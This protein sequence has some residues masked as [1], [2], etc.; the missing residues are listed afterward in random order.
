MRFKL[1]ISTQLPL[2]LPLPD[3]VE[4]PL[5]DGPTTMGLDLL[6]FAIVA[7][8]NCK[9]A[10]T[11]AGGVRASHFLSALVARSRQV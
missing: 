10:L 3:E 5:L 4:F 8:S 2:P 7:S 11:K 9:C 1:G 6:S